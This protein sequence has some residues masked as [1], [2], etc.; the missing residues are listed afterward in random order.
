MSGKILKHHLKYKG[1][2][3][4]ELIEERAERLSLGQNEFRKKWLP[5][6]HRTNKK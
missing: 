4:N 1:K 3:M 6:K 5:E 2:S